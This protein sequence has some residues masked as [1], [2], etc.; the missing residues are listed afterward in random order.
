MNYSSLNF[1]SE[2]Y[3]KYIIILSRK[4]DERVLRVYILP[5]KKKVVFSILRFIK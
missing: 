5:I 4:D 3:H 2:Q 1:A